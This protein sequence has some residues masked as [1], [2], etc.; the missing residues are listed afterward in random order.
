MDAEHV[1]FRL[2]RGLRWLA[3]AVAVGLFLLLITVGMMIVILT[4]FTT[5]SGSANTATLDEILKLAGMVIIFSVFCAGLASAVV[6]WGHFGRAV[7]D[8][9]EVEPAEKSTASP[10]SKPQAAA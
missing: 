1:Q 6:A 5:V 8:I 10:E 2:A 3:V 4:T 9:L 7:D